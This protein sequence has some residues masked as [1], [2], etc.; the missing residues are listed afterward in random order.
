[1]PPNSTKVLKYLGIYERFL[2]VV[3]WPREI[4]L[5]RWEVVFSKIPADN[6]MERL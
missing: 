4:D 2:D 5:K 3:V 1:M 6:R